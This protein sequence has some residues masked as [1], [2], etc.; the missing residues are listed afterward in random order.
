MKLLYVLNCQSLFIYSLALGNPTAELRL[1][2]QLKV[3]MTV[4]LPKSNQ[5]GH[6]LARI[7]IQWQAQ[8]SLPQ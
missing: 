5:K 1:R 3:T 7:F 8:I 4:L 2:L 6:G